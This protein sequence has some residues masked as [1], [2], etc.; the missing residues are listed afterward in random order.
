MNYQQLKFFFFFFN[1]FKDLC[2]QEK[3]SSTRLM[4][5]TKLHKILIGQ[6][7][8]RGGRTSELEPPPPE[9]PAFRKRQ[10]QHQGEAPQQQR[11]QTGRGGYRGRGGGGGHR[12]G[13]SHNDNFNHRPQSDFERYQNPDYSDSGSSSYGGPTPPKNPRGGGRGGGRGGQR[14]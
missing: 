5:A 12:Q 13:W 2:N 9:M 8:D 10:H 11:V 3:T 1:S 6:V 4:T 14:Y 7:P